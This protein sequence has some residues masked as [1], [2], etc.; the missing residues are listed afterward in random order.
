MPVQFR[1]IPPC[2]T[3]ALKPVQRRG[4]CA[5]TESPFDEKCVRSCRAVAQFCH[6]HFGSK[7]L[8]QTICPMSMSKISPVI[9]LPD[10]VEKENS[11]VLRTAARSQDLESVDPSNEGL[12][13]LQMGLG[14]PFI[15]V[16]PHSLP[17]RLLQ[18]RSKFVNE[19]ASWQCLSCCSWAEISF[20]GTR[21][22]LP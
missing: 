18:G 5:R 3:K 21:N 11:H 12:T 7:P 6:V 17:E 4:A 13:G 15:I 14:V 1:P 19:L 2:L 9:G 10:P 16:L 20:Q 22:V 8:A